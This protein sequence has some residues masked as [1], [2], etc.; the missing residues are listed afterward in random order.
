M[1][2]RIEAHYEVEVMGSK[3]RKDEIGGRLSVAE[4]W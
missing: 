3:H 1:L 2:H 4:S